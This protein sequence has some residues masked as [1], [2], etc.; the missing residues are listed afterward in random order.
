MNWIYY[1]VLSR[2]RYSILILID[3]EGDRLV[4]IMVLPHLSTQSKNLTTDSLNLEI[5]VQC[6]WYTKYTQ[7]TCPKLFTKFNC[8]RSAEYNQRCAVGYNYNTGFFAYFDLKLLI[9]TFIIFKL[10]LLIV[11]T[12]K[13]FWSSILNFRD[14]FTRNNSYLWIFFTIK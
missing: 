10:F 6:E 5:K 2:V 14:I 12:K 1:S 7:G 11:L 8:L 9:T 4:M 3:E 13:D